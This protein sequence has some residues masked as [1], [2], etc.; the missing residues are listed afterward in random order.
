[1]TRLPGVKRPRATSPSGVPCEELR[2][3]LVR[4]PYGPCPAA[5]EAAAAASGGDAAALAAALRTRIGHMYRVAPEAVVLLSGVKE[6]LRRIFGA[7]STPIVVFPPSAAALLVNVCRPD[8]ERIAIARGVGRQ[9]GLSPEV[10]ADLHSSSVAVVESPADPLG[11]LLSP[12]DAVRLAR[13]CRLV[14]V[15]ERY[16]ECAGTSLLPLVAELGNIVVLRS[17][18]YWAGLTDPP[19]AWA[20]VPPSLAVQIDFVD[21]D[22]EPAVI[23]AA[24]ATL[25]SAGSIDATL[26]LVRQERS[27]LFRFMR[28]LS[29]VEPVAS[30]GPFLPARVEM[31]P[32]DVLVAGLATY[33]I[34]VH[35]PRDDGLEH[36]LRIGIGGRTAFERLSRA[37]LELSPELV[38]RVVSGLARPSQSHR[39]VR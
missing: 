19:C 12:L 38:S 37:L 21:S 6:G 33:R 11:I 26:G 22:L 25:D 29:F 16:A 13:A 30:W 18:E 27:Q 4:N 28:K 15:D 10:V 14:I 2:L 23:A 20:A 1:M 34:H 39:A 9:A 3:D 36:Y 8:L 32:R 24:M 31:I 5:L 7:L 35:A 17:F